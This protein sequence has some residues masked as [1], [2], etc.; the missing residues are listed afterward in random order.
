MSNEN[1]KQ[2]FDMNENISKIDYPRDGTPFLA[3]GKL[4]WWTNHLTYGYGSDHPDVVPDDDYYEKGWAVCYSSSDGKIF[5]VTK[6]PY[7]DILIDIESFKL[8]DD[9]SNNNLGDIIM[10]N[11]EKSGSG[12]VNED[13]YN[14]HELVSAIES[15]QSSVLDGS[16]LF[17]TYFDDSGNRTELKITSAMG[18]AGGGVGLIV[19]PIKDRTL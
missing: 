9:K 17:V 2:A 16:R 11:S 6:N 8:L 5:T 10:S 15:V 1:N 13:G 12:P 19:E 7:E 3:Y 14:A 18:T 4:A